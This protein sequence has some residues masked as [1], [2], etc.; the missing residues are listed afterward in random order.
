M[1]NF[2]CWNIFPH[3]EYKIHITVTFKKRVFLFVLLLGVQ[4]ICG[5]A[6][7]LNLFEISQHYL[8]ILPH[9]SNALVT[10]HTGSVERWMVVFSGCIS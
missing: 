3:P 2:P 4:T 8:R 7:N 1:C 6:L 5:Q 10:L 9:T